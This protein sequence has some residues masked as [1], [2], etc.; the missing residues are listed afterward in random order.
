[1]NRPLLAEPGAAAATLERLDVVR[2]PAY[3]AAAHV[4]VDTGGRTVDE[5]ASVVLE[6]F[7]RCAG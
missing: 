2:A 5:V 4:A 7:A 3:E 6:E 1:M